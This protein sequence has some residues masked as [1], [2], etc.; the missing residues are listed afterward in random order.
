MKLSVWVSVSDLVSTHQTFYEKTIELFDKKSKIFHTRSHG[1]I[2]QSLKQSG[3]DGVELLIALHTSDNNIEDIKKILSKNQMTVLSIHQSLSN[4][5]NISPGQIERLC[6][7]ANTFTSP[8]VVLHSETLGKK[9]LDTE[10]I[11]MLK[12]LQKKYQIS[13]GV[14]NMT[15][16]PFTSDPF[17]YRG[18]DFSREIKKSGLSITFDTTHLAQAGGDIIRFYLSNKERIINIH[19]SDYKKNWLNK[20]F[21]PQV[22]SHLALGEGELPIEKFL[23]TLKKEKYHGFITMEINAELAQLCKSAEII[24]KYCN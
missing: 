22:Y 14:E 24:K 20:Y 12:S 16:N 15:K 21:I 3:V 11:V 7:I 23:T 9:L 6:Q 10:F 13:F 18:K 5:R 1:Y 19:L 8:I 17:I 2:F 4:K